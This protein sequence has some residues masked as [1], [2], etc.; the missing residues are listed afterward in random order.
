MLNV[1]WYK[2]VLVYLQL[3]SE[4]ARISIPPK[5]QAIIHGAVKLFASSFAPMIFSKMRKRTAFIICGTLAALSM[6][7]G[8]FHN[9]IFSLLRMK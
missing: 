2:L 5:Q 4:N 9:F 1:F 8:T 7:T 6:V 3:A